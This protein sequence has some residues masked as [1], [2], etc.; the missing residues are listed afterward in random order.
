MKTRMKLLC[1]AVAIALLALTFVGSAFIESGGTVAAASGTVEPESELCE[2]FSYEDVFQSYYDQASEAVASAGQEICSISEFSANYYNYET[3]LQEY[4]AAVVENASQP[5]D[6][7]IAPRS[8]SSDEDYIIKFDSNEDK[9]REIYRKYADG[10]YEN[11]STPAYAFQRKF[12][13]SMFNYGFVREGDI[14]LE[15]QTTLNNIGHVACIYDI[16]H[17]SDYGSYIQT[18]DCVMKGVQFG[19]LD[20]N[21][22]VNFQVVILRV[23]LAGQEQR[24]KVRDFHYKQLGKEYNLW[25]AGAYRRLNTDINSTD[26][27]CSELMYAAYKY[28]GIEMLDAV[29]VD[30][31]CWPSDIL[32]SSFT[33]VNMSYANGA[34]LKLAIVEKNGHDWTINV[35]NNSNQTVTV[36]YNKKMCNYGDAQNWT[37][38]KDIAEKNVSANATVEFIVKENWF[39]TSVAFS[40]KFV[41]NEQPMRLITFAD[42]LDNDS[43]TLREGHSMITWVDDKLS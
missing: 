7:A 15:T 8:S 22:M 19:F 26:W 31:G 16:A 28:A 12:V 25:E 36:R 17:D 39:A 42:M 5:T 35:T 1:I 13:C 38:L 32:K 4:T 29:G 24:D 34:Y 2:V 6:L 20:D 11:L 30:G 23:G 10:T 3:D 33:Y 18:I 40:K 27:Y 41:N 43:K 37:G 21:R 9:N 14:L